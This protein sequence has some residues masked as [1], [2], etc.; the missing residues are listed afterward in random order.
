MLFRSPAAPITAVMSMAEA[1][2]L[3]A[4]GSGAVGALVEVTLGAVVVSEVEAILA[5]GVEVA[6]ISKVTA[7]NLKYTNVRKQRQALPGQCP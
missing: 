7:S 4:V 2:I 3:V 5:V 6:G 1:G